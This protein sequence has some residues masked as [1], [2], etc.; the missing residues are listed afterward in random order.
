[1]VRRINITLPDWILEEMIGDV[2][3]RSG[4]ISELVIK[5]F[6]AE[7][8]NKELMKNDKKINN[9]SSRMAL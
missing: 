2:E 9:I 5:R 1:M 3:N 7:Q 6:I 4:R 8:K